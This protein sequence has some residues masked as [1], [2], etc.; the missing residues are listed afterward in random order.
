L[1]QEI[2]ETNYLAQGIKDGV[3]KGFQP[4]YFLDRGKAKFGQVIQISDR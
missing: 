1:F 4:N 2:S 3:K